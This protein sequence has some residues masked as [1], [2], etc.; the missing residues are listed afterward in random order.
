MGLPSKT[1]KGKRIEVL[2][3]PCARLG[4]QGAQRLDR[5]RIQIGQGNKNRT[6]VSWPAAGSWQAVRR[7]LVRIWCLPFVL[8]TSRPASLFSLCTGLSFMNCR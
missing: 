6:E 3:L 7:G 2:C 5:E 1:T 4:R 8:P